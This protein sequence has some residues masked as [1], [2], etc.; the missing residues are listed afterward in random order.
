MVR[1]SNPQAHLVG[2]RDTP[3]C[4]VARNESLAA[5]NPGPRGLGGSTSPQTVSRCCP[6][7]KVD[8][9]GRQFLEALVSFLHRSPKVVIPSLAT[10]ARSS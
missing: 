6:G 3:I 1:V 8:A 5:G 2:R 4:D 10:I 9:N 7:S